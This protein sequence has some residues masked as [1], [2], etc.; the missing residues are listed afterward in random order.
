MSFKRIKFEIAVTITFTILI[1]ACTSVKPYQ[2][3][4]LN[5]REMQLQK[6]STAQFEDYFQSIREGSTPPE[7]GKTNDGCGCK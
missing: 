2:R 1:T 7:S 4:Y 3:R 5:D 6:N